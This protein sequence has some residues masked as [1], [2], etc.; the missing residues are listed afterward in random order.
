MIGNP[1]TTFGKNSQ[2]FN[3]RPGSGDDNKLI[4]GKKLNSGGKYMPNSNQ[5]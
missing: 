3:D 4:N 2:F 1:G 5:K